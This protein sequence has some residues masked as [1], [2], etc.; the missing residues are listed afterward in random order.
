MGTAGAA[1]AATLVGTGVRWT[2]WLAR[3]LGG[4]S[5]RLMTA[6][7]GFAAAEALS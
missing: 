6:G 4:L 7:V 3:V 1:F 5:S 2:A